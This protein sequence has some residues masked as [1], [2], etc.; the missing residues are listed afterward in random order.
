MQESAL[1]AD[2]LPR[3]FPTLGLKLTDPQTRSLVAAR[4]VDYGTFCH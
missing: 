2:R 1:T 4:F 3:A